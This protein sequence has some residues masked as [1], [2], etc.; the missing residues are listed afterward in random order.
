MTTADTASYYW[1]FPVGTILA[2]SR[3]WERLIRRINVQ[4]NPNK[5]LE[6]ALWCLL[7][8]LCPANSV[9]KVGHNMRTA[10][11]L[12]VTSNKMAAICPTRQISSHIFWNIIHEANYQKNPAVDRRVSKLCSD[13]MTC[14]IPKL[15]H[16]L[17]S[18]N[19]MINSKL[20][21]RSVVF[22]WIRKYQ[23]TFYFANIVPANKVVQ[24]YIYS[25]CNVL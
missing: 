10:K 6:N 19:L 22:V 14:D 1:P 25:Y 23:P 4:T 7:V 18:F 11:G 8:I 9:S 17:I 15:R 21:N 12:N 20:W 5:F 16:D 3:H 2:S 24:V 13:V